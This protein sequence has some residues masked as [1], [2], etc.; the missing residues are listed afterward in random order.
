MSIV[1][2]FD[3]GIKNLAYCILNKE[4]KTVIDWNVIQICENTK[5]LGEIS[6]GMI[7]ALDEIMGFVEY[8][9]LYVLIE[10]QPAMK[11]PT[12]KSVQ[13]MLYTYYVMM[14]K[15][16]MVDIRIDFVSASRKLKYM[17]QAYPDMDKSEKSYKMNKVN[18]VNYTRYY[19]EKEDD[20][21]HLQF[22]NKHKKKDDLSDALIQALAYYF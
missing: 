12:M 4:T 19:L 2:S 1:I 10:N 13:I 15:K 7:D 21:E 22:F 20:Q 3:V 8:E 14:R 6:N 9:K 17:M 5:D 18:A 16:M 11:N